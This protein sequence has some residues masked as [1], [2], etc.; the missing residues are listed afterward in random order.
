MKGCGGHNEVPS[1]IGIS[2]ITSSDRRLNRF[3]RNAECVTSLE[4]AL[5]SSV[6]VAEF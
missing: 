6:R 3:C 4:G 2:G 5:F 1:L